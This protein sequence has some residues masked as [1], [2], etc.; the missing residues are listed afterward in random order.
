MKFLKDNKI[1]YDSSN[2]KSWRLKNEKQVLKTKFGHC[3]DTSYCAWKHFRKQKLESF[4][5]FI[6]NAK[7][8]T[9]EMID[10]LSKHICPRDL[11]FWNTHTFTVVHDNDDW[12]WFEYSW[13]DERGCYKYKTF[14]YIRSL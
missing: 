13:Y 5:V 2:N 11:S 7:E 8:A 1:K 14:D 4:R 3:Y 10:Q 6:A 12:I 9:D